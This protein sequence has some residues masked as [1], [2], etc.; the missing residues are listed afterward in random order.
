MRTPGS[1]PAFLTQEKSAAMVRRRFKQLS[2]LNDRL[3]QEAARV[4][5]E[6]EKLP[7]GPQRD[8]LLQKARQ[9]NTA[10]QMDDWLSS[11]GRKAPR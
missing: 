1:A 2:S 7:L 11:P 3:E 10:N 8:E 6:A 4:L 9:L 5:A